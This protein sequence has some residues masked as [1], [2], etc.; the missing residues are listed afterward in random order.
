MII[1]WIGILLFL[2]VMLYL[3]MALTRQAVTGEWRS[4]YQFGTVWTII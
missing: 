1:S 2:L 3:P 4:F